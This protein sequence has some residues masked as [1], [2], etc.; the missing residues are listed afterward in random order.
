MSEGNK[1]LWEELVEATGS[2]EKA[3]KLSKILDGRKNKELT[4][5]QQLVWEYL[6]SGKPLVSLRQLAKAVGI[7]HPQTLVAVLSALTM[8]GYLIPN[9]E[10]KRE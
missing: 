2:E 7:S 5:T 3:L 10:L 6:N 4:A 1:T 9:K 8:K